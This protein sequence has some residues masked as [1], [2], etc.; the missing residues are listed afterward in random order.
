MGFKIR[1]PGFLYFNTPP[2]VNISY[3]VEAYHFCLFVLPYGIYTEQELMEF[4][5]VRHTL[6]ILYQAHTHSEGFL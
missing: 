3:N 6:E 2:I 5:Q 4:G 1:T